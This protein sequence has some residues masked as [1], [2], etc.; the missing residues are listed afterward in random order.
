M[1][2]TSVDPVSYTHLDVYKRQIHD[3]DAIGG[4]GATKLAM[5]NFLILTFLVI[6]IVRRHTRAEEETG[7]FE[8]IGATPVARG[9][10]LA[11]AVLLAPVSYTHL[12][13]YKRQGDSQL[14]TPAGRPHDTSPTIRSTN[15]SP[16]APKTHA[17]QARLLAESC[18]PT[19]AIPVKLR[20]TPMSAAPMSTEPVAG[21]PPAIEQPTTPRPVTTEVTSANS[22]AVASGA[23]R[24]TG[25]APISSKRPVSSSSRVCRRTIA[26]TRN[27]RMRKLSMASFVAPMPPIAS[28]SWMWPYIATTA[29]L[30]FASA[31][32]ARICSGEV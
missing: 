3:L 29:V 2:V 27:V 20:P 26:M 31:L 12:D 15:A 16:T 9:A 24:A 19:A 7:R 17:P 13:V 32:A 5:L 1:A 28:R 4:I 21:Q 10:P 25:V 8:L 6:A 23:P 18:T 11:T 30:A 14:R 22:T